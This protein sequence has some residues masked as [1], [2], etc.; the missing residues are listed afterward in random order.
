[1]TTRQ[2]PMPINEEKT[3]I[4]DEGNGTTNLYVMQK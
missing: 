4:Y 1:M 2:M 3:A